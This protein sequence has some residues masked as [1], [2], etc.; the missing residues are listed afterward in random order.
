[1]KYKVEKLTSLPNEIKNKL[2]K[3]LLDYIDYRKSGL[4]LNHIIG[5]PLDCSY[6]IRHVFNNF[7]MKKPYFIVSD[8]VAVKNLLTHKYFIKNLTPLQLFNRAT[9]PFLPSVK[10][11]T[12]NV[13]RLLSEH[14]LSN[15]VLLITRYI[16]TE[17]DTKKLNEFLPLKVVLLITYS[18]I[19]DKKIE[20]INSEIAIKSLKKAYK[21]SKNYKVILYWRPLIPFINDSD[22]HIKKVAI[23]S[24]HAHATAF[25][26]L[27]FRK[28]MFEYYKENNIHI[29]YKEIARR[30]IL[31]QVLE[32]NIVEKF[33][34]FKGVSLFKKSSC[35]IAYAY[36]VSDYN[37][38]Y[39]IREL[40]DSCDTNQRRICK[41]NWIIPK[42]ID[43][44]MLL[45]RLNIDIG[46]TVTNRA[47]VFDKLS[48]ENRYF[49]QHNLNYQAH[50]SEN[51]HYTGSHGRADIG[52]NRT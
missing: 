24:K 44:Q 8:E 20:P 37:G 28:E 9:D 23:L 16:V 51:P 48:E 47:I 26:G 29:P 33:K 13:L 22:K 30:K 36:S 42:G 41:N 18:G 46:F 25:T 34:K 6:C 4:S 38:H 32:N 19:D 3:D 14:N 52:R 27:F 7:Q 49:I 10:E 11:H 12:F 21:N 43:I 50:S 39:G 45:D 40:C 5:C 17:E 15:T 2:D 31:P 1:M 35:A